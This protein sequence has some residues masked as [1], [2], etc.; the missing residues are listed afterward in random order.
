[1]RYE[2]KSI[3]IYLENK[4]INYYDIKE[5]E[6]K[7]EVNEHSK[8]E[9]KVELDEEEK[10]YFESIIEREDGE[11]KIILSESENE[12]RELFV[13]II[14]YFE[15]LNYGNNGYVASLKVFSKSILFDRKLEKRYRVFQDVNYL[16]SDIVAEINKE[17]VDKRLKVI[18]SD[19]IKDSINKLIIQYEET[20]WEFLKRLAS[21]TQN[22]LFVLERGTITFGLIENNEE[23]KEERYFSNYSLVREE[24]NKY[25]KVFSNGVVGVGNKISLEDKSCG[26]VIKSRIYLENNILKSELIVGDLE[27]LYVERLYNDKIVG[28]RI[29]VKVK[30]VFEENGIAKMEVEFF[31]GLKKIVNECEILEHKY[32]CFEDYGLGRYPLSYQTFYSQS[33]T[34][35]FCTPE[36]N[37]VVEVY[38]SNGNENSAKVSW[39]INNSG[40]GRFSD[41]ER[42]N[43]HINGSNFNFKIEK[44][45]FEMN[46]ERSYT[47]NSKNSMESA[48]SM[49]NKGTKNMV[50]VSD[51]YMGVESIGEMAVYGE[52]IEIIGKSKDIRI[53][54]P[55]EIRIKG[56]RVHNN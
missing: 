54:T 31:D 21:Y 34:G 2:G 12:N 38:F 41:Y 15:I 4:E 52:K 3:K 43:F 49:V 25:Y 19:Q 22:Y 36:I 24:N 23:L 20:N 42:R 1:M 18:I 7:G 39:A 46:V 8:L 45:T 55:G 11:F 29:E 32:K 16:Y 14:D 53:E 50:I 26:I 5:F 9:L 51:D 6:I 17:Y 30:R 33:N 40:N 13:G 56:K 44:D 48:E 10:N 27:K 37:D 35:F 28:S 47:R